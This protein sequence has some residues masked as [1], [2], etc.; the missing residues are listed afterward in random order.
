MPRASHPRLVPRTSRLLASFSSFF[1]AKARRGKDAAIHL[2]IGRVWREN[3]LTPERHASS[4]DDRHCIH[5]LLCASAS[6]RLC[7]KTR[8]SVRVSAPAR[9]R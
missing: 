7:V 2:C 5:L 6:L 9:H 1:N 3:V 4:A 8:A